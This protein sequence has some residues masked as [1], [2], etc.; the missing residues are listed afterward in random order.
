[1]REEQYIKLVMP[2]TTVTFRWNSL[3]IAHDS[4][5]SNDTQTTLSYSKGYPPILGSFLLS[6]VTHSSLSNSMQAS[7]FLQ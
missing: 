1:M 4:F 2:K 5:I 6:V 3:S 7:S